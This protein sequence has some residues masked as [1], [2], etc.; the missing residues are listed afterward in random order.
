MNE[1]ARLTVSEIEETLQKCRKQIFYIKSLEETRA[2]ILTQM[3]SVKSMNYEKPHVS[4]SAISDIGQKVE[5]AYNRLQELDERVA[6]ALET[7]AALRM[8]ALDLIERCETPIQMA[9]LSGYYIRGYS[10]EAVAAQMSY[11]PIAVYK[12]RFSA[13]QSIAKAQRETYKVEKTL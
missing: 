3:A 2:E 13:L 11:T 7:Q 8:N 4:S 9:V 6:A 12:I 5:A 1:G 10:W